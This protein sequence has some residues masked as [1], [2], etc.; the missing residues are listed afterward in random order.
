MLDKL[1]LKAKIL[2]L[3]TAL[4]LLSVTISYFA[5][6]GFTEIE[7]TNARVVEKAAP[8][9]DFIN[10]MALHYRNVR[11]HLRTL[12]LTGLNRADGDAAIKSAIAEILAYDDLNK[13]YRATIVDAEEK[14][15]Y[16]KLDKEWEDFKKIGQRAI[17]LYQA[18]KSE[19]KDALMRIFLV[20]CPQAAA[21]FNEPLE[22]MIKYHQGH[23]HTYSEKSKEIS[24]SA[25]QLIITISL[26]GIIIGVIV[27]F[28]FAQNATK[29]SMAINAIAYNLKQS[30]GEVAS[31][32]NSIASSSVQL[33]QA[34][35]QQAASLQETSSSIEEINSMINSNTESA[36]QSAQYS[37]KSLKSA[38]AGKEVVE[39]MI[40]AM[41]AINNSNNQIMSQLDESNKEMEEIV[42]L[43]GEIGNKTKV[44][45]DIV[46][47]TKL[48]SF[49][50]S[51]EAARAGENGKGFSV[52]AQEVG[53]LAAMSGGA[54][55]EITKMLDNSIQKVASISKN[56]KE[57]VG[58]LIQEGR[59]SIETGAKVAAEC[60]MV[61]DEIVDTAGHVSRAVS[62]IAIAGQ[63]QAQGVQ[64]V[65]RAIAQLDQVTQENTANAAE[66]A[67]ASSVLSEQANNL[68]SLVEQLVLTVEGKKKDAQSNVI[69]I[70]N[71]KRA[72][73]PKNNQFP[74][75]MDSRFSDV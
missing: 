24:K 6:V 71:A 74:S 43:I 16:Q 37:Q 54:A 49:N 22:G 40:Q 9:L 45:N 53:N 3:C 21:Q 8:G 51:V 55:V 70:R 15:I 27:S 5:Y 33:S 4:S 19:D 67:N 41:E 56:Q 63:E 46:F 1:S 2:I 48:L 10:S 47:Q 11:I 13:S 38:E 68:S 59:V 31:A 12:G 35:T 14:A 66:S 52:V 69:E 58:K 62:E 73:K 36:N 20:E 57:K 65:T 17:S 75:A 7:T 72:E 39:K 29:L 42:S 50:A 23:M 32:S 26:I 25:N 28:I 30:A 64:E 44:I 34:T 60:E 18:G 61:L